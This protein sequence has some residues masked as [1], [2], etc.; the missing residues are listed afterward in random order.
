MNMVRSVRDQG[1]AILLIRAP[2][3][4]GV[5]VSVVFAIVAVG[6]IPGVDV[7]CIAM[8]AIPI[9]TM[10]VWVMMRVVV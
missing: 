3:A 1:W 10:V 4:C 2:P 7:V 8:V 5:R 9:V 6:V